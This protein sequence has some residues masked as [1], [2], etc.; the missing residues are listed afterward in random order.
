MSW[1]QTRLPPTAEVKRFVDSALLVGSGRASAAGG[2]RT[3]APEASQ[4]L[5]ERG[6]TTTDCI[7][8]FSWLGLLS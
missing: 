4:V 6:S 3:S 8:T 1:L 7:S 2:P 5:G